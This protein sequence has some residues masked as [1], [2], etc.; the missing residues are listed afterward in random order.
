MAASLATLLVLAGCDPEQAKNAAR[1][2]EDIQTALMAYAEYRQAV[3]QSVDTTEAR[4]GIQSGFAETERYKAGLAEAG[5]KVPP[6]AIRLKDLANGNHLGPH[7]KKAAEQAMAEIER[8][9]DPKIIKEAKR[10]Q[11]R[12]MDDWSKAKASFPDAVK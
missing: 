12:I 9:V 5:K 4:K 1:T 8:R 10:Q 11:K 3:E 7:E 6:E 2:Q